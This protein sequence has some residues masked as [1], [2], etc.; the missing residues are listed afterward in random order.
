MLVRDEVPEMQDQN[1]FRI[2]EKPESE[3]TTTIS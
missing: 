3:L 1:W 2:I